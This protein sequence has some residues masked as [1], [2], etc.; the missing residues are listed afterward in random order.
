MMKLFIDTSENITVGL[1]DSN[2]QWKAYEYLQSKKSSSD[3]HYLIY[4]VLKKCNIEVN[5]ITGLIHC[6]G[7]GSYTGMRISEGLSNIFDLNN[8]KTNSFYHFELPLISGVESG[9]WI[10][11]AFKGEFFLYEWFQA[12]NSKKLVREKDLNN[13]KDV[14]NIFSGHSTFGELDLSLTKDLIF[15]NPDLLKFVVD[16][17]LKREVFYYRSIEEEF[18]RE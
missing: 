16:R 11:K 2:Y 5:D 14:E 17:N 3:L 9:V 18:K 15:D 13:V 10:S 6:S 12:K 4:S 1:L 7:P 8:V